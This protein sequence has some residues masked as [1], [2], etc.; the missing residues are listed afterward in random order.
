LNIG[1]ES[2]SEAPEVR[3]ISKSQLI[4]DFKKIGA[5]EGD[6][7]GVAL[8]FRS[9]GRVEGGPDAFID[10]LLDTI[11]PDGT[12]MMNSYTRFYQV[13]QIKSPRKGR[14]FDYRSTPTWTG[15]VPETFR[16]R[17]G[18][19]RS[20]H[21][22]S[23]IAAT[24]KLAAYLTKGHDETASSYSPY[25]RLAKID[26]KMLYIGLGNDLVS[27]RH[28]AQSLAGLLDVVPLEVGIYYQDGKGEL[29]LFKSKDTY[30]CIKKLKDFVPIIKNLGLVND[31]MIGDAPSML[32]PV[33][34][35]LNAMTKLLKED[36]TLN[37]CDNVT[38]IW[39]RELE[40][41]LNLYNTIRNPAL[42]QRNRLA[43]SLIALVNKHR[44]KGRHRGAYPIFK[45]I[46][47]LDK[48]L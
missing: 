9:V 3:E 45:T 13:P 15:L 36:P 44:L 12:L 31:G 35:T 39:C 8:S 16:K 10:A 48:V 20:R 6:C 4:R 7:L 21:P 17:P 5:K 46:D 32:V 47:L 23:S 19:I 29:K 30:A 43:I 41:R 2:V 27:M 38:C 26:G 11:G 1:H 40:R 18:T 28:E 24:G 34:E 14:I 22:L 25:S 33:R 42:F 37:L